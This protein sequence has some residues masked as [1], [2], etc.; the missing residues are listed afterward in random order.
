MAE[1]PSTAKSPGG[2]DPVMDSML[3]SLAHKQE[4]MVACPEC[5]SM[6]APDAILC[7]N[8]GYSVTSGKKLRAPKVIKEKDPSKLA[9]AAKVAGG[10]ASAT[11]WPLF[12][13]IASVIG[14]A[15]G[16]GIIVAIY[17]STE[18]VVFPAILAIGALA[19]LGAKY[20]AGQNCGAISGGI[21]LLVTLVGMGAAWFGILDEYQEKNNPTPRATQTVLY[22]QN[23][24]VPLGYLAS[25]MALDMADG[26]KS[27][28]WPQ[29]MDAY[30]AEY[31]ED[32]PPDLWRDASAKWEQMTFDERQ[33]YVDKANDDAQEYLSDSGS[34]SGSFGSSNDRSSYRSS[35]RAG[36]ALI[37]LVIVLCTTP[38]LA[39][40]VG[41]GGEVMDFLSRD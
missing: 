10:A 9:G 18:F 2:V 34:Y 7:T 30:T 28:R 12:T 27:L 19:G 31:Q 41:S 39:L 8:C 37:G 25:E 33:R 14:G 4:G 21:A 6:L 29:G 26:G 16:V 3:S 22:N 32:Y 15:L 11:M 1:G 5:A 17:Q 24:E 38:L 40:F 35:R 36:R 23:D 20:G 13:A